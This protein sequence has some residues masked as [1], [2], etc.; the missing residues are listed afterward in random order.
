MGVGRRVGA[1][2]GLALLTVMGWVGCNQLG[3]PLPNEENRG[4][5]ITQLPSGSRDPSSSERISPDARYPA[6]SRIIWASSAATLQETRVLS[7]DLVAAGAPSL[8][9][10]ASTVLFAGRKTADSHWAIFEVDLRGSKPQQRVH[11]DR[12]C[13]NPIYLPDNRLVL[14]CRDASPLGGL[15]S[16][17]SL[18]RTSGQ[19]SDVERITFGPGSSSD[20]TLLDDGRILFS[21]WQAPELRRAGSGGTELFTVNPDGT[22]LDAFTDQHDL[23]VKRLRSRQTS[24]GGVVFVRVD[25]TGSA[26]RVERI[27]M[28]NP[29]MSGRA[30]LPN[31]LVEAQSGNSVPLVLASAEPLPDGTL[32]VAGRS[33]TNPASGAPTYG[34]Y[35]FLPETG[36]IES[37]FDDPAWDEIEAIPLVPSLPR[38][39]RPSSV[40]PE[41]NSGAVL[42]YDARRSDGRVS[43]TPKRRAVSVAIRTLVAAADGKPAEAASVVQSVAGSADSRIEREIQRKVIEE[44][45]SFFVDVPADVPIRVQ[46]LDE[47]GR[48]ISISSWFWIRPGET[49]AC[50]G[51]HE[52]RD[53]APINRPIQAIAH[54]AHDQV[55]ARPGQPS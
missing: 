36:A 11:T 29:R 21:M 27:E 19:G 6:G 45:G 42:C 7:G 32:L 14:V 41:Q 15:G 17:W 49:R 31:R 52:S 4:L 51:C 16:T 8:S 54:P 25:E 55:A 9:P 37:I 39:G 48:E 44:D 50:F 34:V 30:L 33:E 23:V 22:L 46:T 3:A 43:A 24:D 12:D 18:Y 40:R 5:V 28:N 1:L 38:R 20:P 47:D 2:G 35:R 53:A 26:P 13:T 10:D